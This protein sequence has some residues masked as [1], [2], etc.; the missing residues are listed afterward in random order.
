[1]VGA[2]W[3]L[4]PLLLSQ[5]RPEVVQLSRL[6]L[7]SIPP[8]LLS[9]YLLSLL[10]GSMQLGAYNL[11]RVLLAGWYAALVA[12]LF[13]GHRPRLALIIAGQ[14]AGYAAICLFNAWQVQRL[15]RPRWLWDASVFKPLLGYGV[16]N[17]LWGASYHLNQRLDQLV[18]SIWLP[19]QDLGLY[20]VAVTL[21]SPLTIIPNAIGAVLLPAAA[22]E[23]PAAAQGVIR[24]SFRT[25]A[26]L[27]VAA[28]AALYLLVPFLL[29]LFFGASFAP[30]VT[31]CRVL[32][33]AMV[34][35]GFSLVLYESLRALN[36]LLAPAFAE[37]AGIGV[38]LVL[39]YW[40][41]PRYG[42]LGAAFASLGSYTAACLV[43]LWYTR[44]RAGIQLAGT[45]GRSV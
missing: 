18:M 11:S 24:H 27:L 21:A 29:P 20:V 8:A 31:A 28:A 35:L 4:L 26:L 42:Y 32:V 43:T 17:Q 6:F 36:R 25:V 7:L 38:T 39:L 3:F 44:V 41:L 14:L 34:P 12:A 2:G 40:L 9:N 22:R 30:A 33:V 1:V 10:Q 37:L 5:H 45:H 23:S 13:L 19:P 16:R 15:L